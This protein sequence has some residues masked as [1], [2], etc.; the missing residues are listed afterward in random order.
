MLVEVMKKFDIYLHQ[1]TP[2]A[3]V[4]L[5]IFIWAIKS[6]AWSSMLTS[7]AIFISFITKQR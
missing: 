1:L 2:N 5:E 7:F 3:L 6:K 4:R